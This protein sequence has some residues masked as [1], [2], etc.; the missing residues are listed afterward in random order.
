MCSPVELEEPL[1]S[2]ILR[3]ALCVLRPMV[4]PAHDDDAAVR[5]L[6]AR[7]APRGV[8]IVV[9]RSPTDRCDRGRRLVADRG[10]ALGEVVLS[11]APFAAVLLPHLAPT[12]CGGCFERPT[13]ARPASRCSA[14]KRA[15][16]CS[17]A[18]QRAAW[19]AG[20]DRYGTAQLYNRHRDRPPHL[21]HAFVGRADFF[22]PFHRR[23]TLLV[24]LVM[25]GKKT[26]LRRRCIRLGLVRARMNRDERW[27]RGGILGCPPLSAFRRP[28]ATPPRTKRR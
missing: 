16:F 17:R 15:V 27:T 6:N 28:P 4:P 26:I 20:H 2:H 14:C 21:R 1:S 24:T 7:L 5:R 19:R 8:K 23:V 18:C 22:S 9:D 13:D 25:E 11:S 3:A 10:F 12:R